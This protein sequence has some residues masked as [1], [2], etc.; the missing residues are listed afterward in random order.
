MLSQ[1]LMWIIWPAFLVAGVLE[2]LVFAMVD[3]QDLQW[4]GQPIGFSRQGVYTM[5]FFVFWG[6]TMLASGL[7]T[8][9]SMSPFEVNR[10]PLPANA[11]PESCSKQ[12]RC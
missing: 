10:C 7:T 2:V 3:P 8:L 1:R 11:R 6:I 5:A 12:G 9:L 4:F